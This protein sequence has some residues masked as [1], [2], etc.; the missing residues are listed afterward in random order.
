LVIETGAK[1]IHGLE[2]RYWIPGRVMR[3]TANTAIDNSASLFGAR[4]C[5]RF[6]RTMA[7]LA[8]CLSQEIEADQFISALADDEL[9]LIVANSV[10]ETASRL[11]GVIDF[12][13]SVCGVSQPPAYANKPTI[14]ATTTPITANLTMELALDISANGVP[15]SMACLLSK[16]STTRRCLRP[17]TRRR[18]SR[19]KAGWPRRPLSTQLRP[20]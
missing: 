20:A 10:N 14:P 18:W 19:R 16:N 15:D 17:A 7:P 2:E 12:G 11:N 13:V 4:E 6:I 1:D 8:D 3:A 9:R 5:I